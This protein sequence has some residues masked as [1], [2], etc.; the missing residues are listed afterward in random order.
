MTDTLETRLRQSGKY[1]DERMYWLA[2]AD[3]PQDR[4]AIRKIADELR[5]AASLLSSLRELEQRWR[6]EI[7]DRAG[8]G[9]GC[10]GKSTMQR[11]CA[12]ELRQV[13][14]GVQETP[15]GM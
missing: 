3:Q 8:S 10:Y 5:E 12:A 7:T 2:P 9:C 14:S 6:A 4:R 11:Q 13:L 15:D 1:L